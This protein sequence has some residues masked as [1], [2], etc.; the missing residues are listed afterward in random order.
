MFEHKNTSHVNN[1]ILALRERK[2]DAHEEP[3]FY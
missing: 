1:K 3:K 2:V